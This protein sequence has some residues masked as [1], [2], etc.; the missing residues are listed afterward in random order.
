[1]ETESEAK[2]GQASLQL[3]QAA[4]QLVQELEAGKAMEV[5]VEEATMEAAVE[6]ATAETVAEARKEVPGLKWQ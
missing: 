5:M 1:M 6:A 4:L 2:K 3:E